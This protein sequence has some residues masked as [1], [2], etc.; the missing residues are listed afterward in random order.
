LAAWTGIDALTHAIE[1]YVARGAS[2]ISDALNLHAIEL[3][4]AHL[5]PAVAGRREDLYRMLV[6]SCVTGEGF[7]NAGLGLAHALA[8]AVQGHH[9][10][11]HGATCGVFLPHVM[12]F[13][14]IACP[15]KFARVA[16]ALGE[17][18]D[19]LSTVAAARRSGAAVRELMA[20]TGA[21]TTLRELGVEEPDVET[22]AAEA[23]AHFDRP[24]NPRASTVGQLAELYR[25]AA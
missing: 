4:A 23:H 11:H 9:S 19:G 14:L 2:P 7:H 25:A 22:L 13:N 15:D 10:V 18:I 5:R 20:D 21:P 17:P 3:V 8:N 16:R 24:P 12:D 6:A 1:G